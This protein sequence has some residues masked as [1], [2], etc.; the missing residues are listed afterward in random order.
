VPGAAPPPGMAARMPAFIAN[1]PRLADAGVTLVAGT[2]AGIAPIKPPDV[3]RWAV[4]HFQRLG[5]TPAQALR[6]CTSQPAAALGLGHRKGRLAVG[7]DAD[8]VALDGNPLTDPAAL[9]RIRAVYQR[10]RAL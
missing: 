8:L 6:A 1:G 5:L 7:Y 2:D 4:E 10:G 3:V 9:H